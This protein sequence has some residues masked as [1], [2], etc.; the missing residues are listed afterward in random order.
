M[1]TVPVVIGRLTRSRAGLPPSFHGDPG[2]RTPDYLVR[3]EFGSD[4]WTWVLDAGFGSCELVP[5]RFPAGLALI[6][7]R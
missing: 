2:V 1:F 7:H 5:Y 3:T 6:G 4:V